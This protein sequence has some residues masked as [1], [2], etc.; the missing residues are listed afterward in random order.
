MCNEYVK[1][2]DC[3]GNFARFRRRKRFT[4]RMAY[5][6][7]NIHLSPPSTTPS[8]LF[9]GKSTGV[10]TPKERKEEKKLPCTK[11][12]VGE[13]R[14]R[15]YL[16][17]NFPSSGARW[18]VDTYTCWVVDV[19]AIYRDSIMIFFSPSS[20]SRSRTDVSEYFT[21]ENINLFTASWKW[22]A[23]TR[24]VDTGAY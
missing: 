10:L 11:L 4:R 7:P 12:L 15:L 3:R 19:E 17:G 6:L 2:A 16:R 24:N 22:K 18:T 14:E 9:K 20:L 21:D 23:N 13:K 1:S 5:Y 8:S